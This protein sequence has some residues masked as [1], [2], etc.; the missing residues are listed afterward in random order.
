MGLFIGPEGLVGF[1]KVGANVT[2]KAGVGAAI[3]GAAYRIQLGGLC[4]DL[5]RCFGHPG[6]RC[7]EQPL[8]PGIVCQAKLGAYRPAIKGG[9]VI[10]F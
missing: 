8:T 4:G 1:F 2:G 5:T 9:E 7:R 6:G 10:Y 3:I